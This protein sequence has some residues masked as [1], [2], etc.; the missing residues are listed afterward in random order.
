MFPILTRS[1]A[2]TSKTQIKSI[3]ISMIRPSFWASQVH[4]ILL[5][6]EEGGYSVLLFIIVRVIDHKV[7]PLKIYVQASA[8][9][10]LEL[11]GFHAKI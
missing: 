3:R 1:E 4:I 7:M 6:K 5:G 8:D 2:L 9:L 10:F 11:T